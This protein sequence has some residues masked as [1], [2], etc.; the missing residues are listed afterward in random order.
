[1]HLSLQVQERILINWCLESWE[2][3]WTCTYSSLDFSFFNAWKW[4]RMSF[5][6]WWR[7][8]H[9]N[10]LARM[11]LVKVKVSVDCIS[12]LCGSQ[13]WEI[14]LLQ[15][16]HQGIVR[17]WPRRIWKVPDFLSLPSWLQFISP[18]PTSHLLPTNVSTS[19]TPLCFGGTA[20]SGL[21]QIASGG[22]FVSFEFQGLLRSLSTRELPGG[23]VRMHIPVQ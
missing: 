11:F 14:R 6:C 19:L 17:G 15:P 13:F 2:K 7:K 18:H 23:V 22:C 20:C 10:T 9:R 3:F 4:K 16:D 21:D 5:L 1:M 12:V 8:M